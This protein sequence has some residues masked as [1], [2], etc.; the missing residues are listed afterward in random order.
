[1]RSF[2]S[3]PSR[4]PSCTVP[5]T[6]T[7]TRPTF[8]RSCRSPNCARR[9]SLSA[10][11]RSRTCANWPIGCGC[12]TEHARTHRA[13]VSWGSSTTTSSCVGTWRK[14]RARCASSR[15]AS[16]S[17][18]TAGCGTTLSVSAGGL[19]PSCTH[20]RSREAPG[21]WYARIQPPTSSSCRGST[22]RPIRRE[23]TSTRT[24]STGS[25]ARRRRRAAPPARLWSCGSRCGTAR[26][27]TRRT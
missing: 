18:R 19:G 21:T 7:R 13:S 3:R 14:A 25:Q 12:P 1:M 4:K 20:D 17:A 22:S 26:R 2:V 6:S 24:A 16:S 8:C 9:S 11:C 5:K 23:T 10:A 15:P 27:G